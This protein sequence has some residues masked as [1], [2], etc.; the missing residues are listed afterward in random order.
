[1]ITQHSTIKMWAE[2]D[3]PREKMLLKG[4]AALSDKELLAILIGTGTKNKTAVD[5]AEI[6][7]HT[8]NQDLYKLGKLNIAELKKHP[9][10]GDAKAITLAASLELGRRRADVNLQK[11]I[12]RITHSSDAYQVAKIHFQDLDHEEFRVIGLTRSNHIMSV[13]LISKGGRA[14]T[15]ADGKMIFKVLLD[16]KAS[17]CILCHNHPSGILKPSHFDIKLTKDLKQFGELIDLRVLDHLI[18][19][20][21]GYFSFSDEQIL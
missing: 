13:E 21:Q 6:L 15:I 4:K 19:T 3:R 9:G 12:K 8:V 16:M 10:I 7:L 1:M 18:I 20:D 14:G 11:P 5:I 17:A 2:D